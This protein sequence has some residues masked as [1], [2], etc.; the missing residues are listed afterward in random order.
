MVMYTKEL[1]CALR[2]SIVAKSHCHGTKLTNCQTGE[3][4]NLRVRLVG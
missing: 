3:A 1:V 2:V 4:W